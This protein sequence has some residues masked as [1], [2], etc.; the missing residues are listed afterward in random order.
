MKGKKKSN[1]LANPVILVPGIIATYLSDYYPLPPESVWCE[2][3]FFGWVLGQHKNFERVLLHPDK[4]R[5]EALEPA[6]VIPSQIYELAYEDI[7]EEL[8]SELNGGEGPSVPVYPFAYDWRMPLEQTEKK[9]ADFI[10]EVIERTTL[11]GRSHEGYAE[12]D[13]VNLIGHSMGG[14]IIAG[15]LANCASKREKAKVDKV[16]SIATPFKGSYRAVT[17]MIKGNSFYSSAQK[18]RERKAARLTPSL[19]HLIP[20]FKGSLEIKGLSKI[21]GKKKLKD[22]IKKDSSW[23]NPN[24]WQ[25]S[26]IDS[27]ADYICEHSVKPPDKNGEESKTRALKLLFDLLETAR[28]HR[29][30]ISQRNLLEKAGMSKDDWLC[31]IGVNVKTRVNLPVRFTQNK[32]KEVQRCFDLNESKQKNLWDRKDSSAKKNCC[33]RRCDTGD[34]TVPFKG[35]IPEFL[36]YNSLVCVTPDEFDNCEWRDRAYNVIVGFHG[37]LPNMNF[38]HDLIALHFTGRKKKHIKKRPSPP[39]GIK[40]GDWNPPIETVKLF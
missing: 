35:A 19:Y 11:M 34:G 23:F 37:M 6:H 16:V 7:I 17:R 36:S 40:R 38:L 29:C 12:C 30:K 21:D 13:R 39:P 8:R 4:L 27:I 9:L 1:S 26:I 3:S 14:L 32:R 25:S 24:I 2:K 33:N 5:Y 22:A 18:P 15:Y 28:N 31:I 20:S 10:E